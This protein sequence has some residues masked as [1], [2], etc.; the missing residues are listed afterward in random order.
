MDPSEAAAPID[1]LPDDLVISILEFASA[2]KQCWKHVPRIECAKDL[3]H[4]LLVCRRFNR[5]AHQVKILDWPVRSESEWRG[6]EAFVSH[7]AFFSEKLNLVISV[8]SQQEIPNHLLSLNSLLKRL[9]RSVE[10]YWM[11]SVS[12]KEDVSVNLTLADPEPSRNIIET[13]LSETSVRDFIIQNGDGVGKLQIVSQGLREAPISNVKRLD[14]SGAMISEKALTNLLHRCLQLESLTAYLDPYTEFDNDQLD[15]DISP[16]L[17][18][19]ETLRTLHV[20]GPSF[21]IQAPNLVKLTA[22][23]CNLVELDTPSLQVLMLAVKHLWQ[24]V[25][26]VQPC[27][28]LKN[29]WALQCS[30]NS[31][32]EIVVP[33]LYQCPSLEN[34]SVN[35]FGSSTM[36]T[37]STDRLL[38]QLPPWV[39]SLRL[40]GGFA[41]ILRVSQ[42]REGVPPTTVSTLRFVSISGVPN[43][44]SPDPFNSLCEA[45]PRF[46]IL[47]IQIL[48][49]GQDDSPGLLKY[50][51]EDF[52]HPPE[53]IVSITVKVVG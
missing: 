47:K 19:S 39:R 12:E 25:T 36:T 37:L 18:Q 50:F 51:L 33:I 38:T 46:C 21:F 48:K 3:V 29:I 49:T 45:L 52:K 28:G 32:T 8:E 34:L 17:I 10:F 9:P 6:L 27:K 40:D 31:W 53:L 13:I 43:T 41:S 4:A 1:M 20:A 2:G 23:C 14:L 24:P 7:N 15:E 16:A 22:L 35:G 44:A 42:S 26:F 5:L 30:G 11:D